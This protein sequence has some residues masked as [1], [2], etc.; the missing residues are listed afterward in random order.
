VYAEAGDERSVA[1]LSGVSLATDNVFGDDGGA[2]Q[3]GAVRGD[4]ASGY[5]VTLTV[6]VG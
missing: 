2:R 4:V 6:G 3:L 1:A 5:T